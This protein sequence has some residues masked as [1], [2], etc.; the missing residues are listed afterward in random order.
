[1]AANNN[2]TA[3]TTPN[4]VDKEQIFGIALNEMEYRVEMF[5][6]M[7]STCFDKC[8]EKRYKEGE[9]NLGET[10]CI[11]RCTSKYYQIT[12]LV[13]QLLATSKPPM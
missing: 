10:S 2:N 4:V 12:N 8:I 7:T 5:N 1:M 9:L 13:G 11:D 6:K 3:N